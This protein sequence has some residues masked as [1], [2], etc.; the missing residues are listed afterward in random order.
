MGNFF[1][2]WGSQLLNK[3]ICLGLKRLTCWP[4]FVVIDSV[5]SWHSRR[6][7]VCGQE[8]TN[9][10]NAYVQSFMTLHFSL[11]LPLGQ[12]WQKMDVSSAIF[13]L[14]CRK[15]SI[16]VSFWGAKLQAAKATA[17][18][19]ARVGYRTHCHL[20]G[21]GQNLQWAKLSG[22]PVPKR[23]N[24]NKC[25]MQMSLVFSLVW[26]CHAIFQFIITFIAKSFQLEFSLDSRAVFLDFGPWPK[27]SAIR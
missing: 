4:A 11:Y 1:S 19:V 8:K 23:E 12:R 18:P 24:M 10:R 20:S 9:N 6:E 27:P 21:P 17:I 25:G 3:E 14:F 16:F 22:R 2:S 26:S 15:Q 7:S 5:G 13:E